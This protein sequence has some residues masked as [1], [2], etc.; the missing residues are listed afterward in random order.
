MSSVT[1]CDKH[2][3]PLLSNT[4]SRSSLALLT[5]SGDVMYYIYIHVWVVSLCCTPILHFTIARFPNP[6]PAL[7]PDAR[8]TCQMPYFPDPGVDAGVHSQ[9]AGCKFHVVKEGFIRGCFTNANAATLQV[10]GC[11]GSSR[12]STNTKDEAKHKWAYNCFMK[13]GTICP[14]AEEEARVEAAVYAAQNPPKPISRFTSDDIL[15]TTFCSAREVLGN[16]GHSSLDDLAAAFPAFRVSVPEDD[17][18]KAPAS[19]AKSKSQFAPPA[20]P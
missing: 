16:K 1:R 14:A 15:D 20:S 17:K 7:P 8:G 2:A 11:S 5:L 13:H 9:T 3:F 4:A 19:P 6:S 18:K 10:E 12:S